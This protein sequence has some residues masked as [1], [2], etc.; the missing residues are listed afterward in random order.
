MAIL[1]QTRHP[2][3]ADLVVAPNVQAILSD[4]ADVFYEP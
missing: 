4:F 2:V 1:D 3:Q